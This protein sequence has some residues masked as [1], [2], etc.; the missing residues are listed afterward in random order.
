MFLKNPIKIYR[1]KKEYKNPFK[2]Y[3]KKSKKSSTKT[4]EIG[5]SKKKII[6]YKCGRSGH[7]STK[8]KMKDKIK[9]VKMD[10]DLKSKL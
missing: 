1:S 6:C 3:Y 2:H 10:E 7:Y 4:P 9:N 8:C 5:T